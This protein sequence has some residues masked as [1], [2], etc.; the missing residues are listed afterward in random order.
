MSMRHSQTLYITIPSLSSAICLQSRSAISSIYAHHRLMGLPSGR[1]FPRIQ[2][3]TSTGYQ[4]NEQSP[5]PNVHFLLW[6]WRCPSQYSL[7]EEFN[8][9]HGLEETFRTSFAPLFSPSIPTYFTWLLS[10]TTI[11]ICISL[12]SA[13]WSWIPLDPTLWKHQWCYRICATRQSF[14]VK[15]PAGLPSPRKCNY[16]LHP[17]QHRL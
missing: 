9:Q 4:K 12:L 15:F 14:N 3:T 8:C 1:S 10:V 2:L 17:S 5:S 6:P 11:R 16:Q 13:S 7:D